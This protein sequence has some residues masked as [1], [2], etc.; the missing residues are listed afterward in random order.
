MWAH[1]THAKHWIFTPA[2]LGTP[3]FTL[4]GALL[5]RLDL[6]RSTHGSSSLSPLPLLSLLHSPHARHA[7]RRSAPGIERSRAQACGARDAC[8]HAGGRRRVAARGVAKVGGHAWNCANLTL[9]ARRSL[10]AAPRATLDERGEAGEGQPDDVADADV[11]A[12]AAAR[13]RAAINRSDGSQAKE[14]FRDERRGDRSAGDS[15]TSRR[16]AAREDCGA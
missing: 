10:L 4:L 5:S 6:Q 12:A 11:S 14:A 13:R 9:S 16:Y 2:E 1:S 3:T 7:R 8:A 15:R